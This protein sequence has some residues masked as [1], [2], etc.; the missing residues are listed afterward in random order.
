MYIHWQT[1]R[2]LFGLHPGLAQMSTNMEYGRVLSTRR[3]KIRLWST[4][5]NSWSTMASG[6]IRN[7]IP[8]SNAHQ[9]SGGENLLE[10]APCIS[11]AMTKPFDMEV[12]D[13]ARSKDAIRGSWLYYERSNRSDG[14]SNRS[15]SDAAH[16]A[17]GS[18]ASTGVRRPNVEVP[19]GRVRLRGGGRSCRWAVKV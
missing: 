17:D 14:D 19:D 18:P 4:L 5:V 13:A 1:S 9:L 11:M 7:N 2:C 3:I 6:C 8:P 15:R 16:G 12:F 10:T